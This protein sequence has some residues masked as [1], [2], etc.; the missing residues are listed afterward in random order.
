MTTLMILR[1][2]HV[3]F[4]IYIAG[5]YLFLVPILEHRL[6]RLGPAIQ[7]PVMRAL[8]PIL[9]PIN[10]ISFIIII[11]TGMAITLSMRS[12]ALNTLF[13]TAWGWAMIIGLV[14]TLAAAV[15]GFGFLMT[16]G[17][18]MDKLGRSIEGRAPTPDEGK[19]LH[20]LSARIETLSRVNLALIIIAVATMIAS[21]YL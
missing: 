8:M 1:I 4:G 7:S 12:G 9:T 19:I 11:G 17:F 14:A 3:V 16:T 21:R 2:V 15:V 5:S 10:A 13:V 18:R 20:Q 6:K